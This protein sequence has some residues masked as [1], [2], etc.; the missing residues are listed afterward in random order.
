MSSGLTGLCL[1]GP[2]SQDVLSKLTDLDLSLPANANMSC[3]QTS[4]SGVQAMLVRA[5]FGDMP[6]YRIFVSRDLGEHAWDILTEAG[7]SE[8]LTPFGSETLRLLRGEG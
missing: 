2:H 7:S 5:D 3:T 6:A 4:L 1:A 8:G